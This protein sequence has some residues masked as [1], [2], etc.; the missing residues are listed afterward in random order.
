MLE[1][2][3]R[4]SEGV[5]VSELLGAPFRKLKDGELIAS[6]VVVD[7]RCGAFAAFLARVRG[8]R[9]RSQ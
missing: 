8:R 9:L 1:G 4:K 3:C 5:I 2:R 7:S 6:C